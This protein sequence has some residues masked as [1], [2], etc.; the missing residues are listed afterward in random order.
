[1]NQPPAPGF[2]SD[3]EAD[4][5]S[6]E[7][8]EQE[9]ES[10]KAELEEYQG[11]IEELPSIYEGKFQHQLR[12]VAQNIRRLLDERQG[13]QQQIERALQGGESSAALPAA[14]VDSSEDPTPSAV[15][16]EPAA[17]EATP[18]AR[19]GPARLILLSA[20]TALVV[21]ALVAALGLWNRSRTPQLAA[22]AAPTPAAPAPPAAEE[23]EPSPDAAPLS[24]DSLLL[25]AQGECWLELQTLD[26]RRVFM[27]TLQ[28]GEER[29]L[30]LGDGLRLL[31]GRPDLLE[32][33]IGTNDFSTLG[34]IE[35]IE[36]TTLRPQ[37]PVEDAS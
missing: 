6:T 14:A 37:D 31:A 11:L 15:A 2:S 4:D 23:A 8:L 20:I 13:L 16:P 28:K 10:V 25:R 7:A 27:G 12:D 29:R 30:A 18:A 17:S 3:P 32:L 21:A 33:A 19:Q 22:P 26:G 5:T 35:Q 1:M 36:W 9:L 24:P 34:S